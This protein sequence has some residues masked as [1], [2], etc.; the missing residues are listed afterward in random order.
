MILISIS[1]DDGH[2]GQYSEVLPILQKAGMKATLY[3]SPVHIGATDV[4]YPRMTLDTVK[5]LY[6]AGWDMGIQQYNDTTDVPI[7]TPGTN[8]LTNDGAG[9][10]TWINGSNRDH[11]LTSGNSIIIKGSQEPEFNGTFTVAT[12]PN[13]YTFTFT[14]PV[15]ANT[16][17]HGQI[18][19]P[20]PDKGIQEWKNDIESVRTFYRSNGMPRGLDH[21]AYSNGV[22][23]LD[24]LDI[25]NSMG[26]LTG[27]TTSVGTAPTARMFDGRMTNYKSLLD[28]PVTYSFDQGTASTALGYVDLAEA[29]QCHCLIYAH[30]VLPGVGVGLAQCSDT[31]EWQKLIFGDGSTGLRGLWERQQTGRVRVVTISEMYRNLKTSFRSAA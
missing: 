29:N 1:F 12:T 30:A 21:I 2:Q 19:C 6:A 9:N 14:G 4:T 15:T 27:R 3:N 5:L 8:Q 16:T 20:R 18:S 25:V 10:Y 31:T 17:A 13:A 11:N 23:N 24:Y 26:I 28:I 7:N 22:Y